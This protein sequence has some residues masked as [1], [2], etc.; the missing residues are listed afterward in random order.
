MAW[1]NPTHLA[2]GD[3]LTAADWNSFVSDNMAALENSP[4]VVGIGAATVGTNL[5]LGAPNMKIQAVSAVLT[6]SSAGV[7]IGTWPVVFANSVITTLAVQGDTINNVGVVT[8]NNADENGTNYGG[9]FWNVNTNVAI[10]AAFRVNVL[11]IGS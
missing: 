1:T 8:L 7:F 5:A 3:V 10:T 4:Q 9:N 6:P 11:A 2:V